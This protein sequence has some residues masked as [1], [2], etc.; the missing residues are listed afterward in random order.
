[1]I[2]L[3]QL[4]L[5]A[6]LEYGAIQVNINSH[7][8]MFIHDVCLAYKVTAIYFHIDAGLSL[9]ILEGHI[10]IVR[11]LVLRGTR[12]ISGGD[13]KRIIVWDAKVLNMHAP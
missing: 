3:F 7:K 12:I 5:T 11:C 2:L 1:M 9:H 8:E 13:R 4:Q 10:G 6:P